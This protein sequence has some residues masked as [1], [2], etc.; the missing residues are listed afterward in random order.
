MVQ[1]LEQQQVRNLVFM[2]LPLLFNQ[3]LQVVTLQ[4]LGLL[5]ILVLLTVASPQIVPIQEVRGRTPIHL[6]TLYTNSKN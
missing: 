4:E 3:L 5:L 6:V 1:K 2:M